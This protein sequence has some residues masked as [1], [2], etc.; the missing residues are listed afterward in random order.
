MLDFSQKARHANDPRCASAHEQFWLSKTPR[1]L[2]PL[3][4]PLRKIV[5]YCEDANAT[6]QKSRNRADVICAFEKI[7]KARAKVGR[8]MRPL[9]EILTGIE[10]MSAA[11]SKRRENQVDGDELPSSEA[12]VSVPKTIGYLVRMGDW[13]DAALDAIRQA[14]R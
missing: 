4:D 13:E 11:K 12:M 5:E 8:L 7:N 9:D 1:H 6:L 3:F 2:D 14:M 10:L